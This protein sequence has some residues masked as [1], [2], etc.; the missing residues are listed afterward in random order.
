MPF[1]LLCRGGQDGARDVVSVFLAYFDLIFIHHLNP[2]PVSEHNF[3]VSCYVST[4]W[5]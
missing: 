4:V 2:P 5:V 1:R 3:L